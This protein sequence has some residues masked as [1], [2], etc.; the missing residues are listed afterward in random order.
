[1]GVLYLAGIYDTNVTSLIQLKMEE[2]T[3][4]CFP[5]KNNNCMSGLS[6]LPV[7]T[8]VIILVK[9]KYIS[10]Q[11]LKQLSVVTPCLV[12][13]MQ[14]NVSLITHK[15]CLFCLNPSV[16]PAYTV[17]ACSSDQHGTAKMSSL[18][19][20]LCCRVTTDLA[21]LYAG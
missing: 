19:N 11:T 16:F 2:Q 12:P 1:M 15:P 18:C 3:S 20:Q 10:S 7:S 4:H 13:Y 8:N 6:F 17:L 9:R 21:I 14:Q 5:P